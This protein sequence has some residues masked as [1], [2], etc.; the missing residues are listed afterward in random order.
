MMEEPNDFILNKVVLSFKKDR[1]NNNEWKIKPLY[2]Q[3]ILYS[4]KTK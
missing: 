3:G 4:I 1:N 2:I